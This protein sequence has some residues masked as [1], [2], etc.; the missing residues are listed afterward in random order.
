MFSKYLPFDWVYSSFSCYNFIALTSVTG[1]ENP[2][3]IGREADI[4]LSYGPGKHNWHKCVILSQTKNIE[5][6]LFKCCFLVE[7]VH[8]FVLFKFPKAQQLI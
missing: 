8:L 1:L 7:F 5:K 6:V 3:A 2:L 4:F